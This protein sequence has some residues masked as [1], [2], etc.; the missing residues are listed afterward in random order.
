VSDESFL[1][2]R[3]KKGDAAAF[4]RALAPHLPM[5]LAYARAICADHHF[6]EDAVQ[7]T[8]LIA[9]R[10]LG[11][12]FAE[13]DFATW[14]RAITRRQALSARRRSARLRAV[15]DEV[16]EEAY[17]D[18]TPEAMERERLA[19]GECLAKLGDQVQRVVR[20]HYFDGQPLARLATAL[21]LNLNTVKTLL[22]RARHALDTCIRR[23]LA[24]PGP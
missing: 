20:A 17:A 12:L 6:A 2:A 24:G 8:A 15:V 1:I 9:Y 19:L 16:V 3:A 21:G 22:F 11:K 23:R 18:P 13:V 14:L 10:N 5:L 4:E 7:E